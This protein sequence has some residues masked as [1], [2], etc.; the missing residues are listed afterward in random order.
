MLISV[1]PL[2]RS[3]WALV[4]R[5]LLGLAC[6]A[7]GSYD[8]AL[9][10]FMRALELRQKYG[11]L[12]GCIAV[13][14]NLADLHRVAENLPAAASACSAALRLSK[15]IAYPSGYEWGFS[16]TGMILA[17]AHPQEAARFFGV[18]E[19]ARATA[20]LTVWPGWGDSAAE[21]ERVRTALGDMAYAAAFD[22]GRALEP[23]A[24]VAKALELLST[25]TGEDSLRHSV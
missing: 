22:A 12:R 4:V 18:A 24:A 11:D 9:D 8:E 5:H 19:Q 16:Q 10:N 7:L 15:E 6:Q 13:Y 14:G 23:E 25:F 17:T 2:P 20:A 1:I 3:Y 21:I